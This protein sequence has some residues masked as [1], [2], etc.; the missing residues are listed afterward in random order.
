MAQNLIGQT[1]GHFNILTE[2][3]HGGMGAV[4]KAQQT[5]LNRIVAIKVLLS[6]LNNDQSYIARFRQE[7][8]SVASLEHPHIIPIYEIGEINGMHYLVMRYIEGCTLKDIMRQEGAMDVMRAIELLA[9]VCSA[10]DFAHQ[11]GIIHRDIKP[12]NIMVA[13]DGMIYLADFGLA[14][15]AAS[16]SGLTMTGMV[17]GTP[18]YMS[19]EQAQGLADIGPPTDI[20]AVGIIIY[21]MLTGELPFDAG[22]PMA[23]AV[24]RII[25]SPKP[26]R[27]IRSDI[28]QTV[29]DVILRSIAREPDARHTSTGEL[30]NDL[31]QAAI[32]ASQS[33]P[34]AGYQPTSGQTVTVMPG[35]TPP[36]M[37]G[38]TMT[39]IAPGSAPPY[40][41]QTP[42]MGHTATGMAPSSAPP[43]GRQ[44]PPMGH[45]ATGM[46][47][48]GY[49]PPAPRTTPPPTPPA[50]TPSSPIPAAPGGYQSL[51][52]SRAPALIVY[53][54]DISASMTQM[55]GNRR[56]IDVVRDALN[57]ALRQMV[58]RSTKGT[59]VAPRYRVAMFAYSDDVY[60]LFE[61]VKTVDYV[62]SKGVPE[63][64]PIR[65]TDTASAFAQVEY[66]LKQELPNLDRCPAPL[67][68]HMTDGEYTG[69]NPEPMVKRIM[70]MQVSDGHVLVENIFISDKILPTPITDPQQWQGIIPTTQ[71][72]NQ[73]AQVLRSMSSPLPES[74]RL[75]ME[76]AGYQVQQG[77][78]M[79]LPGMS[80]EM[81]EMGF[82]MSTSTPVAR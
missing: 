38:H 25:N 35:Q 79:M 60:D 78:L 77:A 11:R 6:E 63:I 40:S 55:L 54:L 49:T 64:N 17:M 45:T 44:T 9:P 74:Y 48:P 28:P 8:Q 50:Q 29:E 14:R 19:P 24:A 12:A 13:N 46:V 67:I 15:A 1:L 56:R 75:M 36:P 82:V 18:E 41:G 73:Y 57:A 72:S 66:L 68:C 51:A 5:N 34:T 26:P 27:Q 33:A 81:V 30:L 42:P 52:T 22:T 61:G 58:F 10:L 43:Y 62:A 53:V 71:L 47:P 39:G 16:K 70:N 4:Y 76:D 7:A 20:Y 2:L 31:Y 65:G 69:N 59:R 80:P 23:V 21:Q 32:D 37:G 3:G